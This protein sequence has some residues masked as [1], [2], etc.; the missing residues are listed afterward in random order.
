MRCIP[1]VHPRWSVINDTVVRGAASIVR[2]HSNGHGS[3]LCGDPF[4]VDVTNSLCIQQHLLGDRVMTSSHTFGLTDFGRQILRLDAYLLCEDAKTY[5]ATKTLF[6][7]Q[8]NVKQSKT[9]RRRSRIPTCSFLPSGV[10]S[11][12]RICFKFIR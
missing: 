11:R 1:C 3:C 6:K 12:S 4:T 5:S 8:R 2:T 9:T 7:K 10:R